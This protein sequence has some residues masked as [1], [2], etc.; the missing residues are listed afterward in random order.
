MVKNC[1]SCGKKLNGRSDKKF[2]SES[3]KNDFH[4][5]Q[6]SRKPAIVKIQR[7]A[8]RRNRSL[9]VKM[10]ASGIEKI[11]TH[12]LESIGFSFDGLTGIRIHPNESLLL[13]CFEYMLQRNGNSFTIQKAFL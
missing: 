6:H 3:C 8:A 7:A 2:C 13:Y 5:L 9:L 12:E 11:S 4:N 10:E 1:I